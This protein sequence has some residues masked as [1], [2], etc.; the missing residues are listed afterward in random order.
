MLWK[1]T[2]VARAAPASLRLLAHDADDLGL[3]SA[4]LQDAVLK[5]G[6]IHYEPAARR[7]TLALNRFRWEAGRGARER[8]RSAVQLGDVTAL[9]ARGLR[10]G[11]KDAVVDLLA[12]EFEPSEAPGGALTFRF[13]GG[14]DLR[15][16]IECLDLA[17]AD[18]S[19]P[20]SA[21][22]VPSHES[23]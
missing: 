8:V 4:A 10:L 7:L 18:V 23:A 11:A 1:R 20:W 3:I 19:E 6:D 17:L 16:E 22:G 9:K 21:R 12:I 13:A 14:G 15:A 2:E 5:L